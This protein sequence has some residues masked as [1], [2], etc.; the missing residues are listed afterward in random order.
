MSSFGNFS[1]ELKFCEISENPKS[2]IAENFTCL[3][4]GEVK[5]SHPLYKLEPS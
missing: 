4:H 5:N 3:S 2:S 1:A